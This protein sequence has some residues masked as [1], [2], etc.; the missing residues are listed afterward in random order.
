MIQK[1]LFTPFPWVLLDDSHLQDY[2]DY[3]EKSLT[4]IGFD[5]EDIKDNDD[6]LPVVY[7]TRVK[8]LLGEE[9]T[10]FV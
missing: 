6:G 1:T 8:E 5:L 2:T 10:L 9:F 3:V 4:S 7:K